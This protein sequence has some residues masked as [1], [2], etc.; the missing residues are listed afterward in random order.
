ML[1]PDRISFHCIPSSIPLHPGSLFLSFN[2]FISACRFVMQQAAAL[3]HTYTGGKADQDKTGPVG[4]T[5]LHSVY[6][7][8]I[9]ALL[10][11]IPQL[12]QVGFS[13]I[14]SHLPSISTNDCPLSL[15]TLSLSVFVRSIDSPSTGA[16]PG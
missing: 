2:G 12:S 6:S 11:T 8:F 13:L 4:Y 16:P 3:L 7:A 15:V 9:Q 5:L 14:S 10:V 1:F